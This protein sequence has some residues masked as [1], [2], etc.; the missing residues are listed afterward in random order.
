MPQFR[1]KPVVIAAILCRDA[2]KAVNT[3][4]DDLPQWLRDAYERGGMVFASS[5]V[6][7]PTLEGTMVANPDDW[8]IC[9]VRGEVYPCK[10]DIFAATYEDADVVP[11]ALA[12]LDPVAICE[13]LR[14]RFKGLFVFMN[15]EDGTISFHGGDLTGAKARLSEAY[16][17]PA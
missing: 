15:G 17:S 2:L 6:H 4:W 9:G 14:T 8:I 5:S 12:A 13:H 10:P 16:A 11:D 3:N 7:L 1:K